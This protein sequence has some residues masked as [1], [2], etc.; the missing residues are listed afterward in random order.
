MQKLFDSTCM[1]DEHVIFHTKRIN[2]PGSENLLLIFVKVLQL[3]NLM[4]LCFRWHLKKRIRGVCG[5]ASCSAKQV[6]PLSWECMGS[7]WELISSSASCISFLILHQNSHLVMF[8]ALLK[9]W[10]VLLT[11]TVKSI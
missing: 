6:L 4:F 10:S 3:Y 1:T 7:S 5:M 11:T 8:T 9:M 2:I